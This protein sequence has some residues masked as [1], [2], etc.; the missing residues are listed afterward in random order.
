M[1]NS[2]FILTADVDDVDD[3]DCK[4]EKQQSASVFIIILYFIVKIYLLPSGYMLNDKY[5][6]FFEIFLKNL[7]YLTLKV[8]G[9]IVQHLYK[10]FMGKFELKCTYLGNFA[11]I[12]E[13]ILK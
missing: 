2:V 9:C 5:I 11:K 3:D 1:W 6:L 4:R 13:R 12:N 10:Y 8:V 7:L